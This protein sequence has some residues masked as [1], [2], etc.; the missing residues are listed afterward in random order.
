MASLQLGMVKNCAMDKVRCEIWQE[1]QKMPLFLFLLLTRGMSK[2]VV[3]C[4]AA[5]VA[6]VGPEFIP[7][8][9]KCLREKKM[10]FLVD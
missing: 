6:V 8:H 2:R 10:R 9:N 1:H 5:N 7:N 3:F 4:W